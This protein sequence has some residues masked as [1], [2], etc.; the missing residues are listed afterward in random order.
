MLV[1]RT[2][3]RRFLCVKLEHP[4]DC[5]VPVEHSQLYAQLKEEL[6]RG[7]RY[8]FTKE[9][10]EQIQRNNALFYKYIP[11]EEIFRSVFRFATD[12]EW[13]AYA[14]ASAYNTAKADTPEVLQL[15]ASQIFEAMKQHSPAAMRG[16]TAYSLSRVLP[17]LGERL[18]TMKGNVY[19]VVR[20]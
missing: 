19:R 16:M 15:N 12:E 3:S 11:E 10:E 20:V 9:E 14:S 2:G 1:D 6:E 17:Q 4:I 8:W 5:T 18:H 7:E 13:N